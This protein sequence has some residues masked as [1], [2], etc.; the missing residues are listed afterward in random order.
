MNRMGMHPRAAYTLAASLALV[1]ASV[2]SLSAQRTDTLRA[3][4]LLPIPAAARATTPIREAAREIIRTSP[5]ITYSSPSAFGPDW[6]DGFVG[7]GYQQRER[8]ANIKDGFVSAGIGIGN[9]YR[10]VG[11]ELDIVSVST[12]RSGFFYRDA[13]SF[14][15]HRSLPGSASVAVGWENATTTHNGLDGG[16][17]M[18]AV[19][20]KVFHRTS[21]PRAPFSNV[22]ITVGAGNG[23]FRSERAVAYNGGDTK[24]YHGDVNYHRGSPNAFGSIGVRVFEPVSLIADWYGQDLALGISLV[25]FARIPLVITPALSD[26][27]RTAGDGPRFTLGAGLDFRFAS[28][29]HPRS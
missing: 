20:T 18:Y 2:R 21:S 16:N 6:G 15:I 27:T 25:P 4:Y 5:G 3:R 11:V 7:L 28:L 26:V 29:L 23:R 14:K 13:F 8:Y 24:N 17:S 22:S 19:A 10:Y 1:C 9:S 12:V